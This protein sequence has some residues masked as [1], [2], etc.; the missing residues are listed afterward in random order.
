MSIQDKSRFVQKERDSKWREEI[1]SVPVQSMGAF[2]K[3]K[4]E[5]QTT[6][7][8]SRARENLTFGDFGA[9]ERLLD[10]NVPTYMR[11]VSKPKGKRT[12]LLVQA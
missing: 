4:R 12:D 3:Q 2:K 10:D 5:Q 6:D 9:T 7:I 11:H 8:K 1:D